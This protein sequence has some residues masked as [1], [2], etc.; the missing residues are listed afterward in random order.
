[1]GA[2]EMVE[3]IKGE[4]N[5][6]SEKIINE[7]KANAEKK[8][9]DTKKELELQKKR[10]VEAEERKGVEEKERIVRAARQNARKLRWMAEE[11]II[12]KALEAALKH[13]KDVKSEGFEGNS[14]PNILAGLIK[15]STMSITA[16]S[17]AGAELEVLLSEEDAAASYIDQAMLENLTDEI[18]R[19]SGVNV[20]LSLSDE[21]IKSVGGVIV[22]RKDG[23]IEVN[24]TFEERMARLSTSLRE[25]I[26]KTL[27]TGK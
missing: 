9:E 2:K 8:L 21:R 17:S 25:E 14:Y 26:V 11:E 10:F 22:R 23:E 15:D 12:E 16:G 13:L 1:M 4:A 7:A 18:S 20:R 19:D 27:F 24:N 5:G 6:E 3:K